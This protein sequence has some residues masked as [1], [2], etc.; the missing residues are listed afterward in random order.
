MN[1]N[2][3]AAPRWMAA[4]GEEAREPPKGWPD[5]E[6]WVEVTPFRDDHGFVVDQ[7]SE[8]DGS[9]VQ[10]DNGSLRLL[11]AVGEV[12]AEFAPGAWASVRRRKRYLRW[13]K[14]NDE[15]G[16]WGYD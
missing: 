11:N 3:N 4:M 8:R 12:R 2:A 13:S 16:G 9:W 6:V 5:F 10:H 1:G 15:E 14:W 7:A